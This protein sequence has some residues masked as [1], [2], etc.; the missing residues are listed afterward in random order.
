VC[1]PKSPKSLNIKGLLELVTR[2]ESFDL[3]SRL[4]SLLHSKQDCLGLEIEVQDE[5][6]TIYYK[7]EGI[8]LRI[9]VD[10]TTGLV[11]C[12]ADD[13][14]ASSSVLRTMETRINEDSEDLSEA[15]LYLRYAVLS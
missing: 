6:L 13:D 14:M 2:K 10:E 12:F 9:G 3:L 1:C 7:K 15:I 5:N 4:S 8:C 11:R